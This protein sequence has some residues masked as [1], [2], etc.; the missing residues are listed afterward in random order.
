MTDETVYPVVIDPV[1]P[2]TFRTFI[3]ATTEHILQQVKQSIAVLEPAAREQALHILSFALAL[4][5]AWPPVRDLLLTLAP[6]LEQMG[7]RS[8]WL[9]YLERGAAESNKH[10]DRLAKAELSLHIGHLY[11]LLS[12][13][14]H[15][16]QW[17][18][19]SVEEFCAIDQPLGQ[20]RAL[21][22]LAYL[23]WQQHSYAEAE[24]LATTALELLPNTD[25]ERASSYNGRTIPPSS[26]GDMECSRR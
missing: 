25:P 1:A 18:L 22:Q 3:V 14:D 7:L 8:D 10:Q 2:R 16:R 26:V 24:Q 4:D 6:K 17:L 20:A 15:A 11:R 13:F 9:P 23:T 19:R 21:N 5:E 12:Q